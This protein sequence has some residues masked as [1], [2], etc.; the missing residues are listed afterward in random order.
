MVIIGLSSA[1]HVTNFMAGWRVRGT[2]REFR[3]SALAESS[4]SR[5]NAR[6]RRMTSI[7]KLQIRGIRSFSPNSAQT[8]EFQKPLTLCAAPLLVPTR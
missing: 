7:D 2:D 8:L 5:L 3:Q 1:R 6:A 4:R